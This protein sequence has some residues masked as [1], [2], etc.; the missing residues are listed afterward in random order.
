MK[1]T[2]V[3]YRRCARRVYRLDGIAAGEPHGPLG[4]YLN[5]FYEIQEPRPNTKVH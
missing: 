2:V 3:S 4:T 1:K 5:S